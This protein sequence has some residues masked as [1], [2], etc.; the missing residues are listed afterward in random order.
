MQSGKALAR[1]GP[2]PVYRRLPRAMGST[3]PLRDCMLLQTLK[4]IQSQS[5]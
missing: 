2:A 1:D 4:G 3:T 5:S